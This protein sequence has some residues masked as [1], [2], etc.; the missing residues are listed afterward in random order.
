[1]LKSHPDPETRKGL[2]NAMVQ[3]WIGMAA[4]GSLSGEAGGVATS[5]EAFHE[6]LKPSLGQLEENQA[7]LAQ[8]DAQVWDDAHEL[9]EDMNTKA[10][11][12]YAVPVMIQYVKTLSQG[13][14]EE[15]AE[16]SAKFKDGSFKLKHLV[17][18]LQWQRSEVPHLPA[19][20]AA[21]EGDL[22][23]LRKMEGGGISTAP[24]I[25]K[26]AIPS[27]RA[28]LE[29]LLTQTLSQE[30]AYRVT[31]TRRDDQGNIEGHAIGVLKSGDE[32]RLMDPNS[33]EWKATDSTQ[34]VSLLAQHLEEL[35]HTSGTTD[36]RYTDM[37][38]A[39]YDLPVPE[40]S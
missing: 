5:L 40:H 19:R 15:R 30:G 6:H 38:V 13:T 16:V 3:G 4:M 26:D 35:Y 8:M 9:N 7:A 33:A 2:C 36:K 23:T 11:L 18:S 20:M 37:T 31:I 39:R 32:R 1:M 22:A 25:T 24:V 27:D 10:Q 12:D 17:E 14:P 28:G 34:L 29:A 21:W